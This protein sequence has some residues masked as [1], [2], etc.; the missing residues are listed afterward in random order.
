MLL[1]YGIVPRSKSSQFGYLE[2]LDVGDIGQE[3]IT[4]HFIVILISTRQNTTIMFKW[5]ILH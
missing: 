1:I 2:Q 4:L 3:E 5:C